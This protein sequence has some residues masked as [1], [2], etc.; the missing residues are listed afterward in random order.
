MLLHLIDIHE[1]ITFFHWPIAIVL[2]S[3]WEWNVLFLTTSSPETQCGV[4][5]QHG[6]SRENR[7]ILPLGTDIETI[8]PQP[9]CSGWCTPYQYLRKSRM[10][11][12]SLNHAVLVY[13]LHALLVCCICHIHIYQWCHAQYY[14]PN[15]GIWCWLRHKIITFISKTDCFTLHNWFRASVTHA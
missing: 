5:K 2:F 9:S 12:V 11:Y 10:P 8:N 3:L 6:S 1:P 13:C 14:T 7:E 4:I 15:N